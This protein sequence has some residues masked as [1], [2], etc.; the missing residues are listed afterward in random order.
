[1]THGTNEPVEPCEQERTHLVANIALR[2]MRELHKCFHTD[3]PG[4]ALQKSLAMSYEG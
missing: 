2:A 1:M 4:S 3:Y